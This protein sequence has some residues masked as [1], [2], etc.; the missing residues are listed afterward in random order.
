MAHPNPGHPNT[1][2]CR[3]TQRVHLGFGFNRYAPPRFRPPTYSYLFRAF[4]EA[5]PASGLHPA[6][7]FCLPTEP[8]NPNTAVSDRLRLFRKGKIK[9]LYLDTLS[10]PPCP[11]DHPV[12]FATDSDLCPSAQRLADC[13]NYRS[14]NQRIQSSLPIAQMTDNV[15]DLCHQL[16]PKRLLS[17]RRAGTRSRTSANHPK[18]PITPDAVKL[19][20]AK[21]KP[22]TLYGP[23][24]NYT[25]TLKSYALAKPDQ[26]A[27]NISYF[28]TFLSMV[29]LVVDNN[30][31]AA[32]APLLTPCRFL[33]LHKDPD[34]PEK[35]RPIGIG[36]AWRRIVGSTIATLFADDFAAR[37]VWCCHQ[38][39]HQFHAP[40]CHR[41][42]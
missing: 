8:Q 22:G 30:V 6:P 11:S 16:Y 32:V 40:P 35:F 25:D 38:G 34:N 10:I 29:R 20:L 41:S 4:L 1:I 31:P 13:D 39:R 3:S 28:N 42:I 2:P 26:S 19:S 18:I 14:A 37:T 23:Y 7:S 17:S 21:I 5:S 15:K 33:A 12:E 36:T 24:N 27:G 9:Q